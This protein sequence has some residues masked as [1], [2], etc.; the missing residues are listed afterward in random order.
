MSIK[1]T[2]FYQEK[3][4]LKFDFSAG[5]VSSDGGLL[6]LE[7]MSRK[8]KLLAAFCER[9]PDERDPLRIT[10]SLLDLVRQRVVLLAC[11]YED[12]NDLDYLRDDPLLESLFEAGLCS[13]PTMSRLENSLNIGDLYRL[14]EWWIDRYV[15]SLPADKKELTI[16]ADCTDDPTHGNQQGSLFHGYHWQWQYNELFYIDGETGQ[17]IAPILRPGNVHSARWNDRFLG[18]IVQKIKARFPDITIRFRGD[19]G[20]SSASL[21]EVTTQESLEFCVGV[22]SNNRLKSFIEADY[23]RIKTEYGDKGIK[24]QEFFGP[25]EYQAGS[26]EQAQSV[27]VKIESTGK[28]MNVRYI[29]SNIKTDDG[30]KLYKDFYVQRGEAAENRIKE[31]KNMCFSDRLSCHRFSANYFRLMLSALAYELLRMLR[32]VIRKTNHEQAHRWTMHSI[33]LYL[34]KVAAIV[35]VRV[36]TIH[37]AFS[38]AFP[39]QK[40]FK[41]VMMQI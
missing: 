8:S 5:R 6:L 23:F 37:V 4:A 16:D 20:F 36:R 10:H 18:L 39:Q 27:Y 17:I 3:K 21:Y 11:G 41:T 22:A 35:K 32:E 14:G 19:A 7:K 9:I 29:V 12:A 24:H 34:L 30:E 1:T 26:W 38:R 40:L 15:A 28:G 25:F 33:R 2:A 31:I 13:Q